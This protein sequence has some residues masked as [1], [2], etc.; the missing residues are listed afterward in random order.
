MRRMGRGT[1]ARI[2]YQNFRPFYKFDIRLL[3]WT[4]VLS[5]STFVSFV[6]AF[7]FQGGHSFFK[8]DIAFT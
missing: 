1:M 5:I 7:V 4:F 3:N 2:S 8:I 6:S